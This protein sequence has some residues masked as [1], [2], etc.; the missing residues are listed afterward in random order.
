[1]G[2]CGLIRSCNLALF[3]I[4][5]P[6]ERMT[7]RE[8]VRAA[9]HHQTR[10][11]AAGPGQ[12]AGH[13]HPCQHLRRL[14]EALGFPEPRQG[15]GA[16]PDA[17]GRRARGGRPAG[18]GHRARCSCP[19]RCSASPTRT[20]S[21]SPSSTAP[22][23]WSASIFNVTARCQRRSAHAP[24]GRPGGAALR[25][26]AQGRQFLRRHRAPGTGRRGAPG[27]ARVRRAAD[28]PL[29]GRAARASSSSRPTTC[30]ATRT[31]RWSA[32]GGRAASATSRSCPA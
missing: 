16:L 6:H 5:C 17:G 23:C 8:R 21:R 25:P 26:H 11:R 31:S 12:H 20:G 24:A 9:L 10:P 32:A 3:P 13:R 22:R 1:M 27:P 15:G 28:Q 29:H 7:S 2:S 14:R 19:P 30:T 18:G 4:Q